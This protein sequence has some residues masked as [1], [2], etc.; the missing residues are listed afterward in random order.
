LKQNRNLIMGLAGCLVIALLG[1]FWATA[2]MGSVFDYRSPL[3]FTPPAP[4][5]PLGAALTHRVVI[6]LIDALRYDTS[7]NIN[8]MPFLNNLRN[9]S[10]SAKMHS[11]PPSYSE[12]GYT[13][14]LTGAWPDINDGPAVN[15]DYPDIP[16]FTQDDIFSAVHRL[17]LRTAISGYYWFEKL[18]PQTAVDASF[19]TS[20]EDA[21]ADQ[22]V[23]QAA[24][25]MLAGNFQLVLIHLDQVDY[26][27]H[28]QGGPLDPRWNVAAKRAD[29][30][31]GQIVSALDLKQDTVIVLS[32]HG[33]IDRGGHGG[34]EPVNLLEPFVMAGAG[35]RPSS[36]YPDVQQVDVAP[37]VAALLG[38]NFPASAQGRVQTNML[39][40][41]PAY[42]ATIRTAEI[43][44]KAMLF[45]LYT[46]AIK[47]QPT[48]LP[49]PTDPFSFVIGMAGA[50]INRLAAER[51][52]RN[53]AAIVLAI[54][55]A[56]FLFISGKKKLLWLAG[57]ALVYVL[58]FNF[59]YAVMDGR[60]YSLSSVDSQT[61]LLTY[62][63]V[64]A[65]IALVIGW[66]V[67]ML[68]LRLFQ[69]G[70]RKAAENTLGF[71]LITIYLLALP[72]LVSF[73]VNG[74][75][76]TW[77]LPEF[78]TSYIALLSLI[79]WIFVAAFGL[80]LAGAAALIAHYIPEQPVVEHQKY[81]R[82]YVH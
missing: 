41:S 76:V 30:E 5:A 60:T 9:Q 61:W 48:R 13:T 33:Q 46:T 71:V 81:R 28:H 64:T 26:A 69:A 39:D 80:L 8:A 19:Y 56:Y 45:R 11:Q 1:Y 2:L 36:Y 4:A 18:V 68:R 14:L 16:A 42:A 35:V 27:G 50:R 32:D 15:L 24:L 74:L 57:G 78:Y 29:T 67:P 3:R 12:P 25:P 65:F 23:V 54:L 73:A 21:A 79:Q 37:T 66:L 6:V 40:L 75:L 43:A 51:V 72:I 44:Q 59:R 7:T 47:S 31:L 62:T 70:S 22:A 53:V 52:W 82:K 10:A 49:D 34:S 58:V 77:T 55:P 17:G 20:G 38:A 63:A